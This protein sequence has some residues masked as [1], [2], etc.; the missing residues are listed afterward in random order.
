MHCC[1]NDLFVI[2]H[3]K[4]AF[5]WPVIRIVMFCKKLFLL[6]ASISLVAGLPLEEVGL[7]KRVD[8]L[9]L[10]SIVLSYVNDISIIAWSGV[11]LG[12]SIASLLIN[13]ITSFVPGNIIGLGASAASVLGIVDSSLGLAYGITATSAAIPFGCFNGQY[14]TKR[15]DL[16]SEA[17]KVADAV[18]K[19]IHGG[20]AFA[21]NLVKLQDFIGGNST[22]N[23]VKQLTSKGK[24][25]VSGLLNG[26]KTATDQWSDLS[27]K[28]Q[29]DISNLESLYSKLW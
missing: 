27:K 8:C 24:T 4:F 13:L 10:V 18:E 3:Y 15:D 25:L 14:L 17:K 11:N 5:L 19:G 21:Q 23:N 26:T 7:E 29:D 22:D 1:C 12:L 16:D 9:D 2:L 28:Y 6:L 20:T